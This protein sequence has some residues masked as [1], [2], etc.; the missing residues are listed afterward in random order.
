[1]TRVNAITP[2]AMHAVRMLLSEKQ[3][4]ARSKVQHDAKQDVELR[5]QES[6]VH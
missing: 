4:H 1:M 2:F 3:H 6:G 5:A